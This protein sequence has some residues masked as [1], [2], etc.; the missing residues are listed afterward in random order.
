[1]AKILVQKGR[2]WAVIL[3]GCGVTEPARYHR[4]GHCTGLN[5]L[6][7]PFDDLAA[8]SNPGQRPKR[9]IPGG[10]RNTFF[11]VFSVCAFDVGKKKFLFCVFFVYFPGIIFLVS[12]GKFFDSRKIAFWS[13]FLETKFFRIFL[14]F[15]GFFATESKFLESA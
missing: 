15:W 6:I 13:I 14:A 1:M 8:T 12:V 2:L 7:R 9:L 4:I 11:F 10:N 5:P 3:A